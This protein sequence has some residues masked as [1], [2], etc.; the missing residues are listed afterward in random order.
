MPGPPDAQAAV[1]GG[2]L[3]RDK[4]VLRHQDGRGLDQDRID[5]G[6]RQRGHADLGAERL[7]SHQSNQGN[8]DRPEDRL[9]DARRTGCGSERGV[10]VEEVDHRQ[11][12]GETRREQCGGATC[13]TRARSRLGAGRVVARAGDNPCLLQIEPTVADR[14][15]W[16][17]RYLPQPERES[18]EQNSRHQERPA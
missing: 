16:G 3:E 7:Q 2:Q 10:T 14:H 18:H 1:D 5:G 17:P 6:E 4:Q 8:G 9:R 15:I 12:V 13:A 11:E